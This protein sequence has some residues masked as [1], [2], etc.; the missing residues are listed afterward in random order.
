MAIIRCPH[1]GTANREGSNFCNSCGVELRGQGAEQQQDENGIQPGSDSQS[2]PVAP[3]SAQVPAQQY[4]PSQGGAPGPLEESVDTGKSAVPEPMTEP[5][6]RMDFRPE[7]KVSPRSDEEVP[8]TTDISRLLTSVSGLLTPV[9][10]SVSAEDV[11]PYASRGAGEGE[12][13]G[14]LWRQVRTR[15]TTAPQ[16][17]GLPLVGTRFPAPDLQLRWIFALLAFAILV[18]AV[19]IF[20][21]PTGSATQWPGVQEAFLTIDSLPANA[22]VLV[23]WAY[24]P[25]TAGELDLAAQP[26]TTHLLQKK[27]RLSVVSLLPGGPATARR[28]INRAQIEW[29]RTENLTVTSRSTWSIPIVYLSGGPAMLALIADNP[30]A[31]LGAAI[32]EATQG[33]AAAFADR[34]DLA[35]VFAAQADDVQHWLEQVQPL[36]NTPVVA[37]VAAGADPVS[38]PY[39]ESE[40]LVGLVSGFDGAYSYQRLLDEQ[41][42]GDRASQLNM[43]IVLQD[44]GH[45]VFFLVIILGN[46]AAVVRR[47]DTD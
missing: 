23:Y 41:D 12:N 13:R 14:D 42:R 32:P 18:P 6:L 47:S 44:W 26:V 20:A 24:D 35:I 38:R 7:A 11:E 43:Q 37:V 27:A 39:W 1:C 29:Q 25:A 19:S 46:F 45:F 31:A 17:A 30:D 8:E 10:I 5:G 9:D 21:W 16:V 3:P 36:N 33:S 2:E 34:P 28:L 4:G 15:M 40:Q 22:N